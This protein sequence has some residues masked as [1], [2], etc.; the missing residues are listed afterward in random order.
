MSQVWSH[1]ACCSKYLRSSLSGGGLVQGLV[2][3]P[4]MRTKPHQRLVHSPHRLATLAHPTPLDGGRHLWEELGVGGQGVF[5]AGEGR[6]WCVPA[7]P[8][9]LVGHDE[10]AGLAN[11]VPQQPL[12]CL[13]SLLAKLELT[14][15]E[16][17]LPALRVSSGLEDPSLHLVPHPRWRFQWMRLSW[18]S[19]AIVWGQP[20]CIHWGTEG[21]VRGRRLEPKSRMVNPF[22]KETRSTL[23]P[24]SMLSSLFRTRNEKCK[25]SL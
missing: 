24:H 6:V 11:I 10:A 20:Q 1:L 17:Q 25:L 13:I 4:G 12:E 14:L 3:L 23:L 9:F 8:L 5:V 7:V 19:S 21:E 16:H 18:P 2:R 15:T 22:Y